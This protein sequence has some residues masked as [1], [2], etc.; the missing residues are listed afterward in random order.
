MLLPAKGAGTALRR[1]ARGRAASRSSCGWPT[2]SPTPP[3]PRSGAACS[4]RST[5][6]RPPH[7]PP[8]SRS[9]GA[10]GGLRS[11]SPPPWTTPTTGPPSSCSTN[12]S[13]GPSCWSSGGVAALFG[14]VRRT[15]DLVPRLLRGADGERNLTDLEH[16]AELLLAETHTGGHGRGGTTAAAATAVL[17][18]LS[19]TAV[20]EVAGDAVQ[21]RIESEADAVQVMTIH[22]SKGLEFPVVLLPELWSPAA[23]RVQ[24][25]D[26]LLLLRPGRAAARARRLDRASRRPTRPTGRDEGATSRRSPTTRRGARTAATSTV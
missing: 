9:A 6:R 2:T 19:G 20:D 5:G 3:P 11:G 26:V 25:G 21:R 18:D 15:T 17:D 8:P 14:E 13:A 24:A 1:R 4:T 10:S 7:G 22:A 23:T 16:L 12:S